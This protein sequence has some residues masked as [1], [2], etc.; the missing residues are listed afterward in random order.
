MLVDIYK[1]VEDGLNKLN[2]KLGNKAENVNFL[3][4]ALVGAKMYKKQL[5]DKAEIKRFNAIII[6]GLKK[7]KRS[8]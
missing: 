3:Q 7:F 2:K 8:L 1:E 5:I 6:R 4:D